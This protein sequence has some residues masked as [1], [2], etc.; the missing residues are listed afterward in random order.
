MKYGEAICCSH[1]N[2]AVYPSVSV[3][4]VATALTKVK[5]APRT[6]PLTRKSCGN[7]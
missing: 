7:V 4:T 2:M 1:V 5:N 3:G 6:F